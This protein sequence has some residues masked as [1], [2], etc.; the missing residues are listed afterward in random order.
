MNRKDIEIF[1]LSFLDLLSG[2]LGAVIFL[3]IV[4]P[5]GE[6][7]APSVDPQLAVM[8]DTIQGKFFGEIPDS[9][10]GKLIGDSLL[11]VLVDFQRMP[12]MNDIPRRT[13]PV[14]T[15]VQPI[16]KKTEEVE[17]PLPRKAEKPV[18][19]IATERIPAPEIMKNPT[20]STSTT[21]PSK[22]YKGPLPSVPCRFSVELKWESPKDNVDLFLC[23]DGDCVFGAR[24]YR[25]FI[26]YWDSG[27]SRTNI[28]G[29]DLRTSQEA[30]RQFDEIIPGEYVILAQYKSS[31][32]PKERVQI[33]G[34]VYTKSPEGGEA[35]KRFQF[36]LPLSERERTRIGNLTLNA[37]G[38]YHLELTVKN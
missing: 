15:K 2:A 5:K 17:K 19:P 14:T 4:V 11:A 26:G 29:G 18:S 10:S 1:N 8:Y 7:E 32:E 9:L 13:P 33:N 12:G 16:P 6:G 34:L 35:G 25:D 20:S 22:D 3:F 31:T 36:S 21:T 28:F 27:K 24:R 23:K 38:S 37:D 30:V